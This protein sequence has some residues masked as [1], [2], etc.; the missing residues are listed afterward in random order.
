MA[1]G[2]AGKLVA[3]QMLGCNAYVHYNEQR[4]EIAGGEIDLEG[5]DFVRVF[6]WMYLNYWNELF[7]IIEK[8][9]VEKHDSSI[10]GT[11]TAK[12]IAAFEEKVVAHIANGIQG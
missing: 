11:V 10:P 6:Q 1:L 2:F 5:K 7:N 12:I 9:V 3:A 8:G 4:V